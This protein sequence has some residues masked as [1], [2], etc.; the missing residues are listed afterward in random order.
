MIADLAAHQADKEKLTVS[1]SL[2]RP[3]EAA[4]R[5]RMIADKFIGNGRVGGSHDLALCVSI[6]ASPIGAM[7]ATCRRCSTMQ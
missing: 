4:A 2:E 6:L 7:I 3:Q 1:I 5:A